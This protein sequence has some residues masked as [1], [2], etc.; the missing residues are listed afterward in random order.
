MSEYDRLKKQFD[1]MEQAQWENDPRTKGLRAE[2]EQAE[3]LCKA[4]EDSWR[5]T[6]R[7]CGMQEDLINRIIS[8]VRES[9]LNTEK[10]G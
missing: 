6:L 9:I 4:Y 2:L 8:D 5:I 3:M 1:E 7:G 10:E